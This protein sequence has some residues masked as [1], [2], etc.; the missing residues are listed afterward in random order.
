MVDGLIERL[1]GRELFVNTPNTRLTLPPELKKEVPSHLQ[2]AWAGSA[3]RNEVDLKDAGPLLPRPE[4][5]LP[6]LTVSTVGKAH[7][8]CI[9]WHHGV[10]QAGKFI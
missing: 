4:P 6:G 7:Q 2:A 1:T 3:P 10:M 9:L 5:R 8:P